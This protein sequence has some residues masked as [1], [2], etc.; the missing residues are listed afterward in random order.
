VHAVAVT[1]VRGLYTP[2]GSYREPPRAAEDPPRDEIVRVLAAVTGTDEADWRMRVGRP[3]PWM[4]TTALDRDAA[5][6]LVLELRR[7]GL[8]AVS[9]DVDEARCW[10]PRGHATLVLGDAELGFVE[11]PRRIAYDAIRATVLA[12]LDTETT[13]EE[14]ERVASSPRQGQPIARVSHFRPESARSRALYLVLDPGE[15]TVRLEQGAL[16]LARP[17]GSVLLGGSARERFDRSVDAIFAATPSAARDTRLVTARRGRSGF[18][19]RGGGTAKTTSNVRETD[20]VAHLLGI[21][22]RE[23]QIDPSPEA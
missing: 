15:A 19:M 13:T 20:L 17:D 16:R 3:L 6:A 4:V 23:R 11:D 5:D 18:A 2:S 14:V 10:A 12:T 8:G 9:C 22:W 1:R 21:A 7:S